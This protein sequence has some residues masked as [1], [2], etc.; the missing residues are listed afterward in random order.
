MD[1]IKKPL[2]AMPLAEFLA[3]PFE[4]WAEVLI[5]SGHHQAYAAKSWLREWEGRYDTIDA[6]DAARGRNGRGWVFAVEWSNRTWRREISKALG[7]GE[8]VPAEILQ[9]AG[10]VP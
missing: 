4:R 2:W 9:E 3:Q 10:I 7:R 6:R 5:A 1:Q 8:K